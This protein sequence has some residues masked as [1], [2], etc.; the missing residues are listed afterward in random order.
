[1]PG[2]ATAHAY[3]PLDVTDA[4]VTPCAPMPIVIM[5]GSDEELAENKGKRA[6]T[7]TQAAARLGVTERRVGAFVE[8]GDLTPYDERLFNVPLYIEED[9]EELRESRMKRY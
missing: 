3:T 4:W 1:M 7:R 2:A 9:V 8:Q 5:V 6:L